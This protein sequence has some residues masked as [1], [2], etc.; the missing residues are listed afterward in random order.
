VATEARNRIG[1][2][3]TGSD[4]GKCGWHRQIYNRRPEAACSSTASVDYRTEIVPNLT[5]I[6]HLQY[7]D[8]ADSA[9][10]Y[11]LVE[12]TRHEGWRR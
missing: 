3:V 10:S 4:H 6:F 9:V 5:E 8:T 2:R 11:L 7:I 1:R 12:G